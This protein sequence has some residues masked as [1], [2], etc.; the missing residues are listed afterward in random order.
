[1]APAA[2]GGS[3]A[4]APTPAERRAAASWN[5]AALRTQLKSAE[6]AMP[7][8]LRESVPAIE[9]SPAMLKNLLGKGSEHVIPADDDRPLTASEVGAVLLL[10]ARRRVRQQQLRSRLTEQF[11]RT[12]K[13]ARRL[14]Q[15]M[16]GR[17]VP[18]AP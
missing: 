9:F 8:T 2:P 14:K 10:W 6:A 7:Q 17:P 12:G 3:A 18:P 4:A 15:I 5:S 1:M 13:V 16:A 11:R